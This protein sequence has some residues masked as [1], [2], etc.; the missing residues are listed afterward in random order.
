[1]IAKLV[2]ILANQIANSILGI[3]FCEINQKMILL[4][5]YVNEF[6]ILSGISCF[7]GAVEKYTSSSASIYFEENKV[8]HLICFSTR[9]KIGPD[10]TTVTP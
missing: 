3:F 10:V 2:L 8:S 6:K 7:L 1:M 4:L 5:L 9:S